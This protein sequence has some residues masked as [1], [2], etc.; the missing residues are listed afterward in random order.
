MD[1]GKAPQNKTGK[2]ELAPTGSQI[3]QSQTEQ[4]VFKIYYLM[5]GCG[6]A[7]L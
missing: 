2:T 6:S 4:V 5:P 7:V 3:E 1:F